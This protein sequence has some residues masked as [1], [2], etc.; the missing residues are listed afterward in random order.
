MTV[1]PGIS[2]GL[3]TPRPKPRALAGSARHS[4]HH[5]RWGVPPRP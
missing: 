3:L 1:G 4:R 2:P 5:R